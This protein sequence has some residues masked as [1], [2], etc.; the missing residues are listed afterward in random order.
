MFSC[1]GVNFIV[2]LG[3]INDPWKIGYNT[4]KSAVQKVGI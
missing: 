4:F 2:N 1:L 3:D